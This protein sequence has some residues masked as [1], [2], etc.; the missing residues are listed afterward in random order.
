MYRRAARLR[1]PPHGYEGTRETHSI[2][3]QARERENTRGGEAGKSVQSEREREKKAGNPKKNEK[4][5][6]KNRIR[7]DSSIEEKKETRKKGKK[8]RKKRRIGR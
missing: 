5:R 7:R 1:E 2:T 3:A 6:M 8:K 4:T